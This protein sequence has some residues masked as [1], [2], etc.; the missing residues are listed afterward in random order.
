MGENRA[1]RPGDGD[2]LAQYI[3]GSMTFLGVI[4]AT[5]TKNNHDTATPFNDTGN[6]LAGKV[7]MV[8][9]DVAC[10]IYPGTTN[11]ATATGTVTGN[12]Y[13]LAANDARTFTMGSLQGWLACVGVAAAATN[14][15]V[16]EM[17]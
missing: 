6:G 3:N 1:L 13:Y 5:T 4:I 17:T 16:W 12:G 7:L 11:A 2:L 8:Q 9:S 10:Y 14:L 15:K